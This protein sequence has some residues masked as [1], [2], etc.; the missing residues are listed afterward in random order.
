M[1]GFISDFRLLYLLFQQTPP[2]LPP[3][4]ELSRW[5]RALQTLGRVTLFTIV[6]SGCVFYYTTQKDRHPGPQLPFDPSKKNIVVVGSGW[7]STAFLKNLDTSEYN[8][9]VISPRNFFLF[10]PLL[11]S[12]AV[13]TIASNSILQR[14]LESPSLS[15]E[16]LPLTRTAS[17]PLPHSSQGPK[18]CCH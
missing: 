8:V 16:K 5:R 11:P 18:N 10:T 9:T 13:G 1:Y 14:K 15:N 4:P 17:Y 12:V 7:A 3:H 6:T 2:P